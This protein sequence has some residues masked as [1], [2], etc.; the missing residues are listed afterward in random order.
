MKN[1]T[2]TWEEAVP[3]LKSQPDQQKRLIGKD[4]ANWLINRQPILSLVIRYLSWRDR[5]PCRLYY[6]VATKS[7]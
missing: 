2:L 1:R 3:W 6:F 4:A 5:T 7:N